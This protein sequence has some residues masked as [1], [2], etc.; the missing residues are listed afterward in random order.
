MRDF[1]AF[2]IPNCQKLT[3]SSVFAQNCLKIAKKSFLSVPVSF[4][5]RTNS[6]VS[7]RVSFVFVPVSLL[8]GTERKLS[9]PVC[10]VSGTES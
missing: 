6:F 2:G 9:L 1:H 4:L 8:S 3:F 7:L 10:F 5:S